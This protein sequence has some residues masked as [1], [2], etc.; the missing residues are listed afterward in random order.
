[1]NRKP[2]KVL[3]D[4]GCTAIMVKESLVHPRQM[5]GRTRPCVLIDGTVRVAPTAV[6]KI[7]T[8]WFRGTREVVCM[9][10]LLCDL[11]LG[12][13]EGVRGF[14]AMAAGKRFGRKPQKSASNYDSTQRNDRVNF[15][16]SSAN[17]EL[18]QSKER[19]TSAISKVGNKVEA[20]VQALNPPKERPRLNL[21]PRGQNGGV[22]KDGKLNSAIFGDA[23][24]VDT[25]R[26]EIEIEN[27]LK[28]NYFKGKENI[29]ADF[30]SRK[31]S[32]DVIKKH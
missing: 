29:G 11:V 16:K 7:K 30:L 28:V 21:L 2:V 32:D 14:D 12:N 6:V 15:R 20:K 27:K 8:G 9:K 31:E 3:R 13:V 22:G 18:Y 25:A 5:T 17:S 26:R 19:N 10:N 4:T 1:M 23:R 24:P